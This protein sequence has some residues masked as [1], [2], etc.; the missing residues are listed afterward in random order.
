MRIRALFAERAAAAGLALAGACLVFVTGSAGA[1]GPGRPGAQWDAWLGCWEPAGAP[2]GA[3]TALMCVVPASGYSAV[4]LLTVTDGKVTAT[5]H[6]DANGQRVA[7][8]REG[9]AGWQSAQWSRDR[10]RVY[11]RA[12]YTCDNG[13]HRV[14]TSLIGMSNDGEFMDVQGLQAGTR[15][16]VRVLM[17]R[18]A[19]DPGPLPPEVAGAI[20]DRAMAVQAGRVAA[21]A[22][23]A[24]SDI[25]EASQRLDAPVVEAWLVNRGGETTVSAKELEELA[26]AGVPGRVTDIL[27][28]LAY[29][30]RYA[31]RPG[32]AQGAG[33]YASAPTPSQVVSAADTM[34][35]RPCPYSAYA[36]DYYGAC[37]YSPYAFAPWGGYGSYSP[38]GFYSPYNTYSPYGYNGGWSGYGYG[39]GGWYGYG[40]PVIIVQ[41][42]NQQPASNGRLVKGRG[43]VG[44][45]SGGG[46]AAGRYAGSGSGGS[47]AS[48]NAGSSSAGSSSSGS[49]G[50]RTAHRTGGGG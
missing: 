35:Q 41:Q 9:C 3:R 47:S 37:A 24:A 20:G 33:T 32:G 44:G 34:P 6:I 49:S 22:P 36:W 1:Q 15:G 40:Q 27:V 18:E 23:L 31:L 45:G 43:Y 46:G 19:Q 12:D 42:G 39:Y 8:T 13:V 38:Y 25:A 30:Q 16:G 50:G 17:Y 11:L 4:D 28:A 48:A 2:S 26:N 10:E 7:D 5:E 21:S 14:S 29:P